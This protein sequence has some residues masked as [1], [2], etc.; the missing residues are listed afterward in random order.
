[1]QNGPWYII[2]IFSQLSSHSFEEHFTTGFKDRYKIMCIA[3]A[4]DR[5]H[6]S[7]PQF[8]SSGGVRLLP[9]T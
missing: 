3:N 9:G 5:M 1:M 4:Y 7:G 8:A 6:Q 2:M